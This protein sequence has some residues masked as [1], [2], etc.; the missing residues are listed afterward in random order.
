M[1]P[2]VFEV[3]LPLKVP[4]DCW[5]NGTDISSHKKCDDVEPLGSAEN[6]GGSLSIV[7]LTAP[8]GNN[9]GLNCR[10]ASIVITNQPT[11]SGGFTPDDDT[12]VWD[13]SSC[14]TEEPTVGPT[15]APTAAAMHRMRRNSADFGRVQ[16]G[17]RLVL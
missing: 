8:T 13:S 7:M 14:L 16:S 1:R 15:P 9:D 6:P 11:P 10:R 17:K 5:N 2:P 3:A 12:D 4:A